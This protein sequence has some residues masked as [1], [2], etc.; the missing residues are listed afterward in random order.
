[1]FRVDRLVD[2]AAADYASYFRL[3]ARCQTPSTFIGCVRTV[4]L[5]RARSRLYLQPHALTLSTRAPVDR[6]RQ[7][8]ETDLAVGVER[9]T[10]RPARGLLPWMSCEKLHAVPR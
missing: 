9:L 8:S 7:G 2:S 4:H 3:A 1:M 6:D 5:F 10:A